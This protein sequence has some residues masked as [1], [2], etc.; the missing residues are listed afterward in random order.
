MEGKR[1]E[2]RGGKGGGGLHTCIE[3]CL[4]ISFGLLWPL[5]C[6]VC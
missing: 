2:G 5:V 1:G 3:G 4:F 6:L